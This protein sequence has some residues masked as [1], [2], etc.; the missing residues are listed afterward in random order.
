M[1][2]QR[3]YILLGLYTFCAMILS[4]SYLISAN[5]GIAEHSAYVYDSPISMQLNGN[6]SPISS[7]KN[8]IIC[9]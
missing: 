3:I 1:W 5:I 6:D 8:V 2:V 7:N 9:I 4:I